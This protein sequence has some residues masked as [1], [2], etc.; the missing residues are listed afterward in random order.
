M[1]VYID[2][3]GNLDFGEHGTAFFT[4]TG[5]VMRRPF[6]HLP[7]LLD[8]KY[9][10]LETG[11]DLEYFHASEERQ[12]VCDQVLACLEPHLADL[13]AYAIVICKRGLAAEMRR[14]ERLYPAA[15]SQLM[16]TAMAGEEGGVLPSRVIVVTDTLPVRR[17]RAAVTKA[18][19]LA[20]HERARDAFEY[21]ILHH[22]S[23]ADLNLQVADYVSWCVYRLVA[24]ADRRSFSRVERC[25]RRISQ[26]ERA[27]G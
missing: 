25:V 1:Y 6:R 12:A 18:V 23:R 8:A 22:V 13:A 2:E 17:E 19:K 24:R 27:R 10:A 26:L 20:L 5:V 15:F 4:L 7:S 21:R 3:A 9:D 16:E 11:L 14:A